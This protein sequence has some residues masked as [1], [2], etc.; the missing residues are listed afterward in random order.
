MTFTYEHIYRY[1]LSLRLP[2]S[3]IVIL[4]TKVVSGKVYQIKISLF[5]QM[6]SFYV[7][8]RLEKICRSVFQYNKSFCQGKINKTKNGDISNMHVF[9]YFSFF[10]ACC[11]FVFHYFIRLCPLFIC[12]VL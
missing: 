5:M 1:A 9:F 3:H 12:L 11:F 8:H 4:V 7:L 10:I 2:A 6:N